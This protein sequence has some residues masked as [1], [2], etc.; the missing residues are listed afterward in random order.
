VSTDSDGGNDVYERSGTT[1]RL[2]ST[3]PEDA[4]EY[5]EATSR[6]VTPEGGVFFQSN[7]SL[8]TADTDSEEDVYLRVGGDHVAHRERSRGLSGSVGAGPVGRRDAGLP[9]DP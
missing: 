5:S 6:H 2:A 3:G 9:R 8:V 4:H 1:T 7:A